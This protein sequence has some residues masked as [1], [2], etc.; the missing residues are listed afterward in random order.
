MCVALA[1]VQLGLLLWLGRRRNGRLSLRGVVGY[2]DKPMPR[3]KLVAIV[4]ALIA[5]MVVLSF[6]LIPVDNFIYQW[7][8]TWVPFE[9]AGSVTGYFTG[10][11]RTAV[12]VSLA[13]CIPL[14]GLAFPVIEELYFRGF[15][16]PR[17][18]WLG[19]WT[20]LVNAALFSLYHFWAPWGVLSRVVFMLPGVWLVWR[21][22]DLRLSIGMHPGTTLLTSTGGVIA[23]LLNLVPF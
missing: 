2:L 18:S 22:K 19:R 23:L 21:K 3:G 17:L 11:S 13:S 1:P 4:A 12:I 6:A 20:P 16:M 7:L 9:G 5:Q 8:F 14:T 10:Y 15:L